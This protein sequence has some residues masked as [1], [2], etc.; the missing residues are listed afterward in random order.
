[1]HFPSLTNFP[2]GHRLLDKHTPFVLRKKPI[3]HYLQIL[4][5][6][7]KNEQG[8]LEDRPVPSVLPEAGLVLGPAQPVKIELTSGN[9]E[10]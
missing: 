5:K 7:S 10:L 9:E 1:M 8:L 2:G 4:V 6:G 3:L